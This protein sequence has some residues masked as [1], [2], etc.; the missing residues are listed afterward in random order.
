MWGSLLHDESFKDFLLFQD[1]YIRPIFVCSC[2]GRFL[3][4]H[5]AFVPIASFLV[6]SILF[7]RS[8]NHHAFIGVVPVDLTDHVHSA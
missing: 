4:F 1:F 5:Q 3:A 6:L 7:G 8:P 2:L